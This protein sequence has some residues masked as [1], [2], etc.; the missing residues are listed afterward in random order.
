M[1]FLATQHNLS[2][3]RA[4]ETRFKLLS[5]KN[6]S[7]IPWR[8]NCLHQLTDTSFLDDLFSH[9]NV[10]KPNK[11]HLTPAMVTWSCFR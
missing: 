2:F 11:S 4:S 10:L 7:S 1:L 5:P 3:L 9:I 6:P 8:A